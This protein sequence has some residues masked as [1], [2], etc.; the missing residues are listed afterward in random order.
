MGRLEL[1]LLALLVLLTG[2]P[3]GVAF[4]LSGPLFER[5]LGAGLNPTIARA[6]EDAVDVYGEYVRAEKA[7][8]EA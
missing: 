4:W 5:S 7:R 3:L 2:V 8:Q 6:L 1:K